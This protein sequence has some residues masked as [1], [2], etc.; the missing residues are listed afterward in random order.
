MARLK[1]YYPENQITRN[2]Y[3]S[4]KQYMLEDGTEYIGNYHTYSTGEIYTES[5]WNPYQSI[6]LIPYKTTYQV[7]KNLTYQGITKTPLD[8]FVAPTYYYAILKESDYVNGSVNR[9]FVQRNN[10]A[11]AVFSIIEI[12]SKQFSTIVTSGKG[13]NGNLY[14]GISVPW[15]LIGPKNDVYDTNGVRIQPGVEDTNRRV[16]EINNVKMPGLLNY[17]NDFI[18]LSIYSPVTSQVI[19]DKFL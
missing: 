13:I 2:L 3:T 17:V 12:D 15:K 6:K 18:E 11:N 9:Y 16:V 7:E 5:G 10:L 4:G 1:I 14:T 19:K 8:K